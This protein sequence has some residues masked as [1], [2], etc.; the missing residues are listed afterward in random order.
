MEVV[1]DFRRNTEFFAKFRAFSHTEFCMYFIVFL[2]SFRHR[3]KHN[4]EKLVEKI[5][6]SGQ[7]KHGL[8]LDVSSLQRP[9]LHLGLYR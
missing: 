6:L 8:H 5:V 9:K 3:V 7:Q 4:N 1:F 2:P